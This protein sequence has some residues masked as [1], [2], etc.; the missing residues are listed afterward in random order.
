MEVTYGIILFTVAASIV[1]FTNDELFSH[2]KFNAFDAFHEKQWY[3]FFSYGF[4]HANWFHLMINMYV[5]YCF[6]R[7]I[8]VDYRGLFH[9]KYILYYL[10]L[11]MGGLLL[12]ILPAF[13]KHKNDVYYNAVGAS[14]A[15][16]AVIFSAI[17][18]QPT[19]PISFL[20]IPRDLVSIPAWMFAVAYLVYEFIM[21]KKAND[22]IG[23]DA[24]FWGAIY[25]LIFT[26]ALKPKLVLMFFHQIGF[27]L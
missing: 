5:L 4:L 1:G 13:G 24:H 15:I 25:G 27:S 18:I 16:S 6:G 19:F 22:N 3:R 8:E 12:S 26:I 2:L 7:I 9:D 17:L 14:G 10:L 21:T 23:H 11:Y 20:F